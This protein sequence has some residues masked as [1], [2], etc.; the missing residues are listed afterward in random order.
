MARSKIERN[1]LEKL[2]AAYQAKTEHITQT[3]LMSKQS[4]RTKHFE[5]NYKKQ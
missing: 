1:M 5:K 4:D 3:E 2:G